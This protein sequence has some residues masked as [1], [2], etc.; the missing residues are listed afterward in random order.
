[1]QKRCLSDLTIKNDF[2]FGAVMIN[3]ENCKE[4]LERALEIE[5]DRVDVSR[6]K[7][8]VYHPDYKGIRLDVYAKD[9]N[10]TCYNVEMQMTKKPA[11]GRRSRYYQSQM[12]M[13]ILLSGREYAELPDSYVIFICDFDPFGERKYRYTFQM[14]CK[15]S[16]Q[17]PLEDGRRIVFLST[18]GENED[19]ISKELL[20]FLKF[21]KA[22]LKE[23]REMEERFMTLEEMLKDERKEGLKEGT[24]KAQKRIVSKMLSKGLSD[25]EIMELCDISLEELENLKNH[26]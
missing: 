18:C 17:T 24:V 15:E 8:M 3:P 20:A 13:D 23:S 14:Q 19:E 26:R 22:D 7:S 11:L 12:D 10:N 2:M 4:F 21:V 25:E 6:E 16:N 1:M 5:I 9:E